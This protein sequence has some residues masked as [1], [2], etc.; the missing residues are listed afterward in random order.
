MHF[1]HSGMTYE[2]WANLSIQYKTFATS[3]LAD[4]DRWEFTGR[5]PR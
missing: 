1:K 3:M 4:Y 2:D 5:K